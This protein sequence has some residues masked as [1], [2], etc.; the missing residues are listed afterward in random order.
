MNA[1]QIIVAAAAVVFAANAAAWT[2]R[3]R[4]NKMD[5]REVSAVAMSID[6]INLDFPYAGEQRGMLVV[7]QNDNGSPLASLGSLQGQIDCNSSGCPMR[8]KIDD[9]PA[10]SFV[11]FKMNTKAPSVVLPFAV[12]VELAG[13]SRVVFE[14]PYF[15]NGAQ[16]FTFD[17]TGDPLAAIQSVSRM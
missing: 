10:F 8:V 14:V 17:V 5:E 11:A 15:K 9:K 16:Y 2:V 4:T 6:T 13:A 1:K 3:D 7:I 12:T